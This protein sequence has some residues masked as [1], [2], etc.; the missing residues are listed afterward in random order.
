VKSTLRK[1]GRAL[2]LNGPYRRF[3]ARPKV[4]SFFVAGSDW[5][6]DGRFATLFDEHDGRESLK[7][8]HFFSIYDELFAPYMEGFREEDGSLRPVRFLE[9][10]VDRGGSLELWR[11]YFGPDAVIFGIDVNPD[12]EMPDRDDLHVRI[13]SQAD[14]AFLASVI[15]EMGGVDV[16]LDD[17]SHVAKHQ[18]ASFDALF[19][20]LSTGG[21]YV[22][23][24]T[25]TSYWWSFQ[26]GYRRPGTIVQVAKG[27]VDGLSK[28]FYRAPVSRR[29]RLAASDVTSIRFYDSMIAFTKGHRA[30]PEVRQ[31][32]RPNEDGS[33]T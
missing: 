6:P 2:R 27:M 26:G 3:V 12:S 14:P 24:D 33:R 11:K 29:A 9:I 8:V 19:P 28:S 4:S 10:G 15:A 23:E 31:T 1:I 22:V 17:G 18:R 30:R 32:R 20:A 5:K 13:G 16:V 7:W 25:H 21:L